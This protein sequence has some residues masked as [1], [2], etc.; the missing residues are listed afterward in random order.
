MLKV[1]SLTLSLLFVSAA[2]CVD[3]GPDVEADDTSQVSSDLLG[4]TATTARP[5]VA[6]MV[7][8]DGSFCTVTMIS[9]S[10]F[11]TSATCGTDGRPFE[12]SVGTQ[13]Q[14]VGGQKVGVSKIF[15]QA[16]AM[17]ENDIAVGRVTS[18]QTWLTPATIATAE[19]SNT[20]LT[21]MG[22]GCTSGT[23]PWSGL[24]HCSSSSSPNVRNYETYFYDGSNS[25][26]YTWDDHGGPTFVGALG[27]NGP[28]V[29]VIS[30][31]TIP[32]NGFVDE[33]D[34]GADVVKYRNQILA[35]STALTSPGI[36]YRSQV[37]GIGWAPAV[38]NGVTSGTQGRR[39]EGLQVWLGASALYDVCYTAYVQDVGWQSEVCGGALAGTVGQSKRMEAVKV[40]VQP[41]LCSRFGSCP[42]VQYRVYQHGAWSPWTANNT[43]AGVTGASLAI[44]QIEIKQ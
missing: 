11:V 21:A 12:A 8:A 24:Y 15:A 41:G 35:L 42:G 6:K 34:Q 43:A 23:Y 13:L 17:G 33:T 19:P 26:M 39:L 36:S 37:Q 16:S 4:G 32:N 3:A 25:H 14:F 10:T 30:G 5:E 20:L 27:D 28:I 22:D 2:A 44:E 9:P 40:R 31:V 18:P 1:S 29:R 7:R 38:Q